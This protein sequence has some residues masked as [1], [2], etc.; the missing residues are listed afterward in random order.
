MKEKNIKIA[1]ISP[2]AD[3][4]RKINKMLSERLKIPY[5]CK[6][7]DNAE[8]PAVY[9]VKSTSNEIYTTMLAQFHSRI[10]AE[11]V[12]C[13]ISDG[14]VLDEIVLRKQEICQKGILKRTFFYRILGEKFR[15]FEEKV[16]KLIEDYAQTA[17]SNIYFLKNIDS[18][19]NEISVFFE[20]CT[21]EILNRKNIAHT[22]ITGNIE[23]FLQDISNDLDN[24]FFQK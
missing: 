2:F 5:I 9:K 13:F 22:V 21:L 19:P 16:E 14:T 1:I 24:K 15:E 23:S 10:K 11:K 3:E 4:S 17:Y 18:N 12:P 7:S 6:K 20:Y 8:S